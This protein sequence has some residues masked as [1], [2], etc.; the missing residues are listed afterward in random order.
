MSV[1]K[2]KI[3]ITDE[4]MAA[5]LK[6][7]AFHPQHTK[8]TM[9][10]NSARIRDKHYSPCQ[11]RCE[12]EF[13]NLI[14]LTEHDDVGVETVV[15]I[16][17]AQMYICFYLGLEV[18]EKFKVNKRN[19][20]QLVAMNKVSIKGSATTNAD[21]AVKFFDQL[22]LRNLEVHNPM[23]GTLRYPSQAD[24]DE[25]LENVAAVGVLPK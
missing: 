3:T 23:L 22:S 25:F 20:E 9:G 7:M 11:R 18:A 21:D 16:K 8:I 15:S 5:H 2:I 6:G 24:F 4:T 13:A 10:E 14:W 19:A 17:A 12:L 1:A